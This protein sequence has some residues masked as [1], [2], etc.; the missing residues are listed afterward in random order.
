MRRRI[1]GVV[2]GLALVGLVVWWWQRGGGDPTRDAGR[3]PAGSD[4]AVIHPKIVDGI[5][6]ANDQ[7]IAGVVVGD[8]GPISG[9]IV[10]LVRQAR[11]EQRIT[12]D[13]GGAFDFGPQSAGRYVVI[14]DAP[15]RAPASAA[16]D[17]QD[18]H[19]NPDHLKLF[20]HAC[21]AWVRGTVHDTGGGTIPRAH[22]GLESDG[23]TSEGV[24]AD[25]AG[26][27]ELCVPTGPLMLAARA[28]GYA[29][30]ID[31]VVALGRIHHDFTLGPEGTIVGH[32]VRAGGNEPVAGAIVELTDG[33]DRKKSEPTDE[34]GRFV[35][36]AI[37]PGR[38]SISA[39]ADRLATQRPIE[40]FAEVGKPHDETLELTDA[41][42]ITGK[43]VERGT[44]TGVPG[45]G[46]RV[47][48][49]TRLQGVLL[50]TTQADGS[51]E[52]A[53]VLPGTYYS[54]VNKRS[55]AADKPIVV[56]AHD[57]HVTLEVERLASVSGRVTRGHK[58][59]EGVEVTGGGTS[60]RSDADGV[61][62]LRNLPPGPCS[63]YAESQRVGAFTTGHQITLAAGEQKQGVELELDL[64]ASIAGSV[65]D[66]DGAAVAGAFVR[67]SLIQG[68]DYGQVVTA[69]D[70]SFVARALS[71]GGDYV[72][73][74]SASESSP[75]SY[76]A[77]GGGRFL[78]VTVSGGD[79][80]VTG[81]RIA[82]KIERLSIAGHVTNATGTPVAD[83]EVRAVPVPGYGT[84][85]A[86]RTDPTGAF[87]VKGL[88]AGTYELRATGVDGEAYEKH[89][90]AGRR[91]LTVKLAGTGSII[92]TIAG[93][94]GHVEVVAFSDDATT[95]R[96]YG[97]TVTGST[98]RIDHIPS[99]GYQ[100][101]A[102]SKD[103]GDEVSVNIAPG[104]ATQVTLQA[105]GFGAVSG[106][107]R[108]RA[109]NEPIANAE[110]YGASDKGSYMRYLDRSLTAAS[111]SKTDGS[112]V[113]HLDHVIAGHATVTCGNDGAYATQPVELR[114]GDNKQ[115][116]LY[117]QLP[118]KHDSSWSPGVRVEEQL[119]EAMIV[120]V[121]K[122]GPADRAGVHVGDVVVKIDD[123]A[124]DR[125]DTWL[126]RSELESLRASQVK[127]TVD[128][129]N[130]Q[131]VL[132]IARPN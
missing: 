90:E 97:A 4:P 85:V 69:D 131:L 57:V 40:T 86:T 91:G 43:L 104:A 100:V 17:L 45:V 30:D 29:T 129:A 39:V 20:L 115:L 101:M 55:K 66:Q 127:L 7:T 42:S 33:N 78:P 84:G 81:L 68:H 118:E 71:G 21:D 64:A 103:D 88:V 26:A 121:T 19:A 35:F 24:D 92:G 87:E 22:V 16:I 122:D 46:V 105:R 65:V 80:H 109:T 72:Y 9:A 75:I 52:I 5:H 124:F 11:R 76:R 93:L 60:A 59:V 34:T 41:Y 67:F 63:L 107:L 128:R 120:S 123:Q 83:V 32:A 119:D 99:G 95:Y 113:Y 77:A 44:A 8:S 3:S 96:P 94:S 38:Y 14:G 10:R 111:T 110:C 2:L 23:D 25:D 61:F 18:P 6:A 15:G 28:D 130:K 82:V 62:T 36:D 106:T 27:F 54:I 117:A 56:E 108:D 102:F 70:G 132:T 31:Y 116:D 1:V 47:Y 48:E 74:V 50:A 114:A 126:V 13:A 37:A 58:P 51:F 112:G 79:S 89:V 12:T 49:P 73:Q 53:H 125:T 98:F